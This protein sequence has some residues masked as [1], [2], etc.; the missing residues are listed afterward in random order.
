M[1]TIA[2]MRPS[3]QCE[4]LFY[5]L[6]SQAQTS[7]DLQYAIFCSLKKKGAILRNQ[8]FAILDLAT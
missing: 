3:V 4:S 6:E 1:A 2:A 8:N 5:P 7:C